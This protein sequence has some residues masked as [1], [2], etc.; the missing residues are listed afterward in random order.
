MT[1]VNIEVALTI[2]VVFMVFSLTMSYIFGSKM[3]KKTGL[4]GPITIISSILTL[5]LG[6]FAIVGWFLYSWRVNEFMFFGGL[7]LGIVM[8]V[9][10][11]AILIIMLFIRR[12]SMLN[13]YN[14]YIHPNN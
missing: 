4:F 14:S 1:L 7:V 12:K 2:Y 8:L 11:E 10:S 13:T 3:I 9:I 5:L 6:V